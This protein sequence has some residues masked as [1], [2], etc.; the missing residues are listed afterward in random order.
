MDTVKIYKKIR[1]GT[2][3]WLVP[4][5]VAEILNPTRGAVAAMA[6][7]R[8]DGAVTHVSMGMNT[9][10]EHDGVGPSIA[11]LRKATQGTFD[12]ALLA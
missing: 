3:D 7:L 10:L 5:K 11:L 12:S 1:P 6:K 8:A 9:T 4:K 2:P